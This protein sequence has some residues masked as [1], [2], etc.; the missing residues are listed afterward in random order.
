[1][2]YIPTSIHWR[3]TNEMFCKLS[4]FQT[5]PVGWQNVQNRSWSYIFKKNGILQS[6]AIVFDK[7]VCWY[8]HNFH[9]SSLCISYWKLWHNCKTI[10]NNVIRAT[11]SYI[12]AL[13]YEMPNSRSS[14]VHNWLYTV[15]FCCWNPICTLLFRS[16]HLLLKLKFQHE[17][18]LFGSVWPG[19][20]DTWL[21]LDLSCFK[22][23]LQH[24]QWP[25]LL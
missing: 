18:Y 4:P 12:R 22:L 6:W 8:F 23:L 7:Y 9:N 16:V 14:K 19:H 20:P 21:H 5:L 15:N 25:D 3:D 13:H 11:P 2:S 10:S 1:M 24:N 17:C